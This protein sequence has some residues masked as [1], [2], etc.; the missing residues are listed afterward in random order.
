MLDASLGRL[1][2]DSL[3][4]G[5]SKESAW[6]VSQSSPLLSHLGDFIAGGPTLIDA[7]IRYMRLLEKVSLEGKVSEPFGWRFTP[8]V[9]AG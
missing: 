9:V 7:H 6:Q 5:E 3:S 4:E 8:M 1:P 2:A